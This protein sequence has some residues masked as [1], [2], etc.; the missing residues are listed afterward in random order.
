MIVRPTLETTT[1]LA[2]LPAPL[3]L[4]PCPVKGKFT[5]VRECFM[6][7]NISWYA[8]CPFKMPLLGR[9]SHSLTRHR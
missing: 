6:K 9:F 2:M 5:Q 1:D 3:A 8:E 4:A 7:I